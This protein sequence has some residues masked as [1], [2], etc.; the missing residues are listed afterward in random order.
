MNDSSFFDCLETVLEK[1]NVLNES[2]TEISTSAR[3]GNHEKF[4]ESIRTLSS[5]VIVLSE[6]SAH[7]AYLVGV[8]DPRSDPAIP[9]NGVGVYWT[10]YSHTSIF[11]TR[12]VIIIINLCSQRHLISNRYTKSGFKFVFLTF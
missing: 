10:K 7:A 8:S 3:E 9:G 11:P 4:C 2:V 12:I 6:S 1:S 5:C